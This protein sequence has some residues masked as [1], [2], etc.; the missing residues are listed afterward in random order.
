MGDAVRARRGELQL[1]QQRLAYAAKLDRTYVS[2][3]ERGVK[4]LTIQTLRKIAAG[5]QCLPS[6]L[7]ARAE[8]LDPP[9]YAT[10]S[11]RSRSRM[12][13]RSRCCSILNSGFSDR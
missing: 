2:G 8:E 4:N 5:L 12:P 10:R 11:P 1:S 13:S 9:R 7:L 3:I 6:E